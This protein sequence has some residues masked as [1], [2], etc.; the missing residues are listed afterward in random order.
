MAVSGLIK[1]GTKVAKAGKKPGRKSKR[2]RKPGTKAEKEKAKELGIT[3]PELRKRKKLLLN[4]LG[5]RKKNIKS[6]FRN[7]IKTCKI[8]LFLLL[9]CEEQW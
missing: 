9:L 7:I 3:V 6:F 1:A 2:G 5:K 8:Y 4:V